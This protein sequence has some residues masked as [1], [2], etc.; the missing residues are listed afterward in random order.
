MRD[1]VKGKPPLDL[2]QAV[3]E[4]A[5]RLDEVIDYLNNNDPAFTNMYVRTFNGQT[6]DVVGVSSVNGKTGEVTLTG[7]D[8]SLSTSDYQSVS[9]V[10][11]TLY[12]PDN[13]PPY[14][15]TSV[16]TKT[17]AVEL[18][19]TDIS[20]SEDNDESVAAELAKKYD[21]SNPPP[22]PVTSVNGQTG[23]VEISTGGGAVDSVNGKTGAVLLTATDINATAGGTVQQNIDTFS[24]DIEEL[25]N[26]VNT[27]QQG[28]SNL[29]TEVDGKYS[30]TNPPP[31][32]VTSVNNR[33]GAV[34]GLANSEYHTSQVFPQD[35]RIDLYDND[36][37]IRLVIYKDGRAKIWADSHQVSDLYTS[38]FPP[39]YPVTSVNSSN[40]NV[41]V[42]Y[43]HEVNRISVRPDTSAPGIYFSENAVSYHRNSIRARY[44]SMLGGFPVLEQLYRSSETQESA[45]IIYTKA[46]PQPITSYISASAGWLI[47]PNQGTYER[48]L[49]AYTVKVTPD[50]SGWVTIP[51][52]TGVDNIYGV[53]SAMVDGN[54][55]GTLYSI[56]INKGSNIRA[57]LAYGSSP[58]PNQNTVQVN[59]LM[60]AS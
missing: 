15:V 53:Y 41:I 7:D 39:P 34:K 19:G 56:T 1:R 18:K 38:V 3:R 28:V 29:E 43:I 32:P 59:L 51:W 8:I 25:G 21:A 40:G 33:I 35:A 5:C 10:I 48:G 14:P 13:A 16:N 4:I 12:G 60:I 36:S 58:W 46:N 44:S 50:E 55:P 47:M 31:Y 45:T 6:G 24:S 37:N 54:Y 11:G 23:D 22:Y 27:L 30:S 20:V 52:L 9:D 2:Y 42:K 57:A 49:I 17:G 26:E